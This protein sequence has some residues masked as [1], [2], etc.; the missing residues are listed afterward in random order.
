MD[1]NNVQASSQV[2]VQRDAQADKQRRVGRWKLFLIVG[3]CA[4]P[5]LASYFTYYVIKPTG[6]TNYGDLIDPRNVPMP[7]LR[8]LTLDGKAQS[9]DAYKGK[10]LLVQVDDGSCLATCQ[11]KLLEMRQQRLMQGKEM[12]RIERVWLVTGD[13]APN[14]QLLHDFDGMHVLHVDGNV[15]K[16]WLPVDGKDDSATDHI[17]VIDPVGNLMFRFPKNPDHAKMKKD[18]YKL[19]TASSIG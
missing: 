2:N 10:W 1:A 18:I 13:Q 7:D 6:R 14:A 4:V 8:A 11:A 16:T 9:L 19:L 15:V 12:D 5:V 3:I 17:Y